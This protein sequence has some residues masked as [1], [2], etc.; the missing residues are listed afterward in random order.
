MNGVNIGFPNIGI[1]LKNIPSGISIFGFEIAFYGMIIALG[2]VMGY[3]M[4]SRQAKKTGQDAELYLDF[5]LYA[6]VAAVIGARLYYVFFSWDEYKDNLLEIFHFRAGGL[7]IYGGVIA[8]VITAIVYAKVKKVNVGLLLD[9]GAVG[10]VTGQII[11]RWGN[12]F[13]CEAFGGYAGGTPLAMRLPWK[14]AVTHMSEAS[15]QALQSK[16][17]DGTILVHP[18][19]LYESLWN[20]GVLIF[21]LSFT[22]HKKFDGEIILCY[23]AA[24]GAG[25]AWIEALRTD[26]L[27]L[28]GTSIPVSQAL[29]VVM[30]I[31][32]L[33]VIIIKRT[34]QKTLKTSV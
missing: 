21:L 6:I 17:I 13:N 2:M 31:A 3:L 30:V 23:L 18:T 11:G 12:F 10:L 9:T 16:V 27:L 25:R 4:A 5:T 34:K 22:K 33:G 8:G 28:W 20:V 26:Q 32:A 1:E 14:E 7:A 24:Y 19:F 29:S 15:A